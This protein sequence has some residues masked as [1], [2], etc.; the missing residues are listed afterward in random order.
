MV[1][2]VVPLS[3]RAELLAEEEVSMH[4]L[5]HFLGGHDK[6]LVAYPGIST[7]RRGGFKV[8]NFHRKFFGS[9]AAHNRLLMW[10]GFY[11]TF[12]DYEYILMYASTVW[13][14]PT[15]SRH[16][17]A[18]AWTTS[19]LPGFRVLRCLGLRK[20]VWATAASL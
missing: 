18:W 11:R 3:N 2:I 19:A 8:L 1:A 7:K 15:R 12:Q 13:Y 4:Q 17:A 5:L 9:A 20:H 16:G 10:A 14:S 6:Y